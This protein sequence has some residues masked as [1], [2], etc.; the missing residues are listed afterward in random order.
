M[1]WQ[2][3]IRAL[4]AERKAADMEK[5]RD[6]YAE[7]TARAMNKLTDAELLQLRAEMAEDGDNADGPGGA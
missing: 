1:I 4:R 3:I 2:W 7:L 5:Q 6:L